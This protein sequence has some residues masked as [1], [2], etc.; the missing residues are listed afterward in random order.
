MITTTTTTSTT[1]TTNTTSTT[2]PPLPPHPCC[3][4]IVEI[5]LLCRVILFDFCWDGWGL[6]LLSAHLLDK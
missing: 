5:L 1:S 2:C 3:C 6:S 4:S